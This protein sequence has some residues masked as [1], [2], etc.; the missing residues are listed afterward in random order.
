[1]N[2]KVIV[3]YKR[4]GISPLDLIK[5]IKERNPHLQKE[6]MAYAGRLDPLAEGVVLLI[7]GKELKKFDSYLNLSKEY[8]TKILFG[9]SSDTYD[10]LGIAKKEE[11]AREEEAEKVLDSFVG[12]FTFDLPPFSSYK[13]K[14]K[15][16]FWWALQK[17]VHEVEVP[18]REVTIFS[19]EVLKK[20][21]VNEEVLKEEIVSKIKKVK[22]NFRQ[23]EIIER[24]KEI[25]D[26][27]KEKYLTFDLKISCSSGCYIRSIAR[28]AGERLQSGA[29]VMD[30]QRTRVGDYTTT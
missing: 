30:L 12:N 18:K 20:E 24:W 8:R 13:I 7:V 21:W 26:D 6:R 28:E 16:L 14:G 1:M 23:E 4:V 17:R 25:L 19:L 3:G 11:E 29:V 2:E 15:P 27:K 22:G 10:I 5:E 9:F